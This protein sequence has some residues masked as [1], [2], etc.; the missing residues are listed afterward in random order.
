MHRIDRKWTDLAGGYSDIQLYKSKLEVEFGRAVRVGYDRQFRKEMTEWQ[1]KRRV[2]F[3]LAAFATLSIIAL[4]ITLFYFRDLSCVII[5]W[6][7]L[8]VIIL[9]T[10]AIAGRQYILEM[11]K[12]RPAPPSRDALV[13][14]LEGRWWERISPMELADMQ[15]EKKGRGNFSGL[16]ALTLPESFISQSLSPV[17]LLLLGPSG[18]WMFLLVDWDGMISKQGSNWTQ[19]ITVH[20]KLGRRQRE[21]KSFETSPDD[22]WL[23]RKQEIEKRIEANVPQL[24]S[25][26]NPVRGGI[27][28]SNPKVNFDKNRVQDNTAAY[29]RPKGWV[30]RIRN[31]PTLEDFSL[32][33]Q[34]EILDML[35]EPGDPQTVSAK[36]EAERLYKQAVEELRGYITN[37]VN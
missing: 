8:V 5:Y 32:E 29:G 18:I 30:A 19:T 23:K 15:A 26:L 6:A 37:L 20:D 16:L 12:D 4:C 35:A 2:F 14:D 7:L 34:L 31:S 21:Q 24:S 27:V 28:F 9:V 33:W 13:V 25:R 17:D 36:D 22:Q 10:L 1:K 11:V 3:S